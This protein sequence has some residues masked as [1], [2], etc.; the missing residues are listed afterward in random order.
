M[1]DIH[2]YTQLSLEVDDDY[3]HTVVMVR[4][5]IPPGGAA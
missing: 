5:W 2:A 4:E 1:T 3:R